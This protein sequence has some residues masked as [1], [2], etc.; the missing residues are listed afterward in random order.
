MKK[1]NKNKGFTLVELIV[2]LAVM[3]VI[4]SVAIPNFTN[5]KNKSK[6]KADNQT[7]ETIK[8][9]VI[10]LLAD[11]S[12]EGSEKTIT[13][14]ANTKE[15]QGITDE[16]EKEHL[17]SALKEV[18]NPATDSSASYKII[19]SNDETVNVDIDKKAI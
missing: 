18:K 13:Y 15:I 8:R 2:V 6:E 12:I 9:T 3:A 4:S 17:K 1:L 19:I 10:M 5:I 11:E 14:N 7:C 16:K